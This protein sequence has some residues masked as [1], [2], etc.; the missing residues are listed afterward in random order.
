MTTRLSL[1][2]M[3]ATS[4]KS[5]F[6]VVS[7]SLVT[8]MCS[9]EFFCHKGEFVF[10]AGSQNPACKPCPTGTYMDKDNHQNIGCKPCTA[11]E[12]F[13]HEYV[14]K[15][16]TTSQDTVV[17]CTLGYYRVDAEYGDFKDGEC[18]SCSTCSGAKPHVARKCDEKTDTVCCPEQGMVLFTDSQGRI[19]CDKASSVVKRSL[20]A[21]GKLQ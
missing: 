16:C 8:H 2:R 13:L 3:A 4:T 15:P 19:G 10:R 21:S 1:I 6:I 12:S 5:L 20:G 17:G 18:L 9:A 7:M 11:A 14:I